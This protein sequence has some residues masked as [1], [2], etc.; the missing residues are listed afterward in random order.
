VGTSSLDAE[1]VVVTRARRQFLVGAGLV[2]VVL[3]AA[4]VLALHFF[5]RASATPYPA[6][7]ATRCAAGE[8]MDGGPIGA[9]EN[10]VVTGAPLVRAS[11][12]RGTKV[13]FEESSAP[14]GTIISATRCN[15]EKVLTVTVA[16]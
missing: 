2:V 5:Y 7:E 16:R 15:A 9:S 1:L 8:A 14:R 13:V 12:P 4:T 10:G 3:A 6:L 11:L